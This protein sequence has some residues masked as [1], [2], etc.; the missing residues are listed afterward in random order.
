MNELEKSTSLPK[1]TLHKTQSCKPQKNYNNEEEIVELKNTLKPLVSLQPNYNKHQPLNSQ[2]SIL[3][4]LHDLEK[5]SELVLRHEIGIV[6]D[7]NAGEVYDPYTQRTHQ[8]R[9]L[10]T[11]EQFVLINKDGFR[12]LYVAFDRSSECQKVFFRGNR[13]FSIDVDGQRNVPK[14]EIERTG[15][16][17]FNDELQK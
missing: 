2:L 5:C 14:F 13:K 11:E 12:T 7:K 3:N 4:P 9:L 8:E 15:V 16:A 6:K 17:W 1:K 10:T